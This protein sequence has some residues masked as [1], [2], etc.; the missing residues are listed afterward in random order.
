MFSRSSQFIVS[1]NKYL[2]AAKHGFA[3]GMRFN[4][5]FEGDDSP[6]K[7][8][9]FLVWLLVLILH[10]ISYVIRV[11]NCTF[12]MIS[13][14]CYFSSGSQA[15]LSRLGIVLISGRTLNGDP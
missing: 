12:Y 9:Y 13:I 15:R 3:V 10:I 14:H 1:V 6:D 2:E 11:S 8:Y 5:R 7:R 4:M